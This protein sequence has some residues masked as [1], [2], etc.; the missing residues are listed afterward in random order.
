MSLSTLDGPPSNSASASAS[1][2]AATTALSQQRP[3]KKIDSTV[4]GHCTSTKRRGELFPFGILGQ[5]LF[6][7]W[8]VTSGSSVCLVIGNCV[9]GEWMRSG[10]Q[11]FPEL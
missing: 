3:T 1:A 10:L 11:R 7:A 4:R 9:Q 5:M 8:E 6:A 2:S